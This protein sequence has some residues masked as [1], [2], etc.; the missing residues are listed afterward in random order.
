MPLDQNLPGTYKEYS[1]KTSSGVLSI[2]QFTADTE[3]IVSVKFEFYNV[4][5]DPVTKLDVVSTTPLTFPNPYL[6]FKY[7]S[8][9]FLV[10]GHSGAIDFIGEH[11]IRMIAKMQHG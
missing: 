2:P 4:T 6:D 11:K 7:S 8:Y 10:L 9:E 1:L 5:K 3:C